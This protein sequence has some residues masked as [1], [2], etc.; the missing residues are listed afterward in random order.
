MDGIYTYELVASNRFFIGSVTFTVSEGTLTVEY[1][2]NHY[3]VKVKEETLKIYAS[4][5]DLKARNAVEATVGE[6]ITI[7]ESFGEDTNVIVS[8]VLKGDYNTLGPNVRE[9]QIDA[10]EIKEMIEKMD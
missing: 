1:K 4:M 7:A 3:H 5:A 2:T 9:M 6:P 10:S 8:L